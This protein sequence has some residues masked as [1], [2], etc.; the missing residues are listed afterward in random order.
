MKKLLTILLA[1][2]FIGFLNA[3]PDRKGKHKH[4]EKMDAD[5]DGKIT[6]AEWTAKHEARFTEADA[7]KDGAVQKRT[8]FYQNRCQ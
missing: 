3:D 8:S 2:S 5:K 7:N 1:L 4:F 6:K